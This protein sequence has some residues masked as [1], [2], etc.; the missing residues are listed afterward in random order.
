MAFS[1]ISL[2]YQNC[3]T[4]NMYIQHTL[5]RVTW[6]S[7]FLPTPWVPSLKS[8]DKSTDKIKLH[9]GEEL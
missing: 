2:L 7:L 4:L 6:F 9:Q 1:T 5:Q 3:R 8:R